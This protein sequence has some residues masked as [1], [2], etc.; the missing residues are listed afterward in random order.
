MSEEDILHIS[1]ETWSQG[2]SRI[3]EKAQEQE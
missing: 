1:E 3:T 2:D